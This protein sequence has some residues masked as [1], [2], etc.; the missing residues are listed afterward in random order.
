M[1]WNKNVASNFWNASQSTRLY[2][3]YEDDGVIWE[4][5]EFAELL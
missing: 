2:N 1:Y 3:L 5:L 4:V